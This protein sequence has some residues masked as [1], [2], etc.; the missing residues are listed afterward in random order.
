[1]DE[2]NKSLWTPKEIRKTLNF[3]VGI[4]LMIAGLWLIVKEVK[5]DGYFDFKSELFSGKLQSSS[6]GLFIVLFGMLY[7]LLTNL[8]GIS[9]YLK[10]IKNNKVVAL[11]AVVII[12]LFG[13]M[14]SIIFNSSSALMFLV[15]A[16]IPSFIQLV[17]SLGDN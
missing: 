14:I 4:I 11:I 3:L 1:M 17:K 9:D 15:G 13:S 12:L 8:S 16:T 5:A 2:Q 6:I 7:L 10:L